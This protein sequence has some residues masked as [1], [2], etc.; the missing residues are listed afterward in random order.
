MG[1]RTPCGEWTVRQ[2]VNHARLDQQAYGAVVTG[3]G[4]PDSDP[5]DPGR[6]PA[7]T[8]PPGRHPGHG[9]RGTRVTAVRRTVSPGRRTGCPRSAR[10]APPG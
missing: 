5:P 7:V 2:V 6:R 4:M 10:S 9:R 1:A 3:H 8:G